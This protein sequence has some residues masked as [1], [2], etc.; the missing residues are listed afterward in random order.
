MWLTRRIVQTVYFRK[1]T[2]L[3]YSLKKMELQ[4]VV[5]MTK[6][7]CIII[8]TWW[9]HQMEKFSALL[10]ICSG[11]SPGPD[12]FPAGRPVTRSFD[13]FFQLRPNE[14]LSKK[15]WGWWF[16][17]PSSPLW[18]HCNELQ[19]TGLSIVY[20]AKKYDTFE[21]FSIHSFQRIYE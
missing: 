18:R 20:N 15:W 19:C 7:L 13:V 2:G 12:E 11:K 1:C 3:Y 21:Y 17:T 4:K 8:L 9:R 10:A 6:G 16:E 5:I 14:R